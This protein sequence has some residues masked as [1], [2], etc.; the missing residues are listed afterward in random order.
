MYVVCM[1]SGQ[2]TCRHC[3]REDDKACRWVEG[4]IPTATSS[5]EHPALQMQ[6]ACRN[7]PA[8]HDTGPVFFEAT[9]ELTVVPLWRLQ[10][11]GGVVKNVLPLWP[12]ASDASVT[13]ITA[14]AS[15]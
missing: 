2:V 13:N 11:S 12:C 9:M 6:M 7:H 10:G 1:K 14:V 15:V 3:V 4:K 8:S 5:L